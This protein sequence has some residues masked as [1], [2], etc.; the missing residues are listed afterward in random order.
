MD[1]LREWRQSLLANHRL[2]IDTERSGGKPG[3]ESVDLRGG[4][5]A[6]DLNESWPFGEVGV[7]RAHD[8][9][10][11]LRDPI[12]TMTELHLCLAPQDWLRS[13]TPSTDGRG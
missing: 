9:L 10:E 12:H 4:R 11:H 8:A 2:S 3:Y 1:R 6:A 5:I 7:V 13:Q